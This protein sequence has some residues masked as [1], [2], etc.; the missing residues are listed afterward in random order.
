MFVMGEDDSKLVKFFRKVGNVF[1][2]L[3]NLPNKIKGASS[4]VSNPFSNL[5]SPGDRKIPSF[6]DDFFESRGAGWA[7]Y[8]IFKIQISVLILFGFGAVFVFSQSLRLFSI[9]VLIV[10]SAYLGLTYKYQL[11]DAFRFDYNAYRAFILICIILVWV[12]VSVFYYFPPIFT[13]PA[14][15]ALTPPI[16]LS[17]LV[18]VSFA[19]FRIKYGREHTYGLVK[20]VKNDNVKVKTKYDIRSNTKQGEKFLETITPVKEGDV[21]KISVNKPLL[22]LRGSEKEKITEKAPQKVQKIFQN[23]DN[24]QDPDK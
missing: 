1:L 9:L 14:L 20:E 4:K 12:A 18:L 15:N 11:K 10:L 8:V 17:V 2:D 5:F 21:V 3:K 16:L 6:M 13:Q 19:I 7:E 23:N 22:G 24:S